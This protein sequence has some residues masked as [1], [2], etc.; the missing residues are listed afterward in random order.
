MKA[1]PID[2]L[3]RDADK[4]AHQFD[5]SVKK[6]G[7][8]VNITYDGKDTSF[9]IRI[10]TIRDPIGKFMMSVKPADAE[11]RFRVYA[12]ADGQVLFGILHCQR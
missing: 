5:C 3:V 10:E 6:V 7:E 9:D 4:V 11:E 1:T 2:R 12:T 8:V